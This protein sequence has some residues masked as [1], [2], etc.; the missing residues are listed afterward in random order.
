MQ[1]KSTRATFIT[2]DLTIRKSNKVCENSLN[3]RAVV[4]KRETPQALAEETAAPPRGK[5]AP[6]M[7]INRVLNEHSLI[8]RVAILKKGVEY[9]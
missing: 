4:L 5:R 8:Y 2:V 1:E 6:E 3:N 7:E 9:R